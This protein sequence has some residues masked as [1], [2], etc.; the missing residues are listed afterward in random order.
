[1]LP[2]VLRELGWPADRRRAVYV[3]VF[4]MWS[5]VG[6]CAFASAMMCWTSPSFWFTSPCHLR[7]GLIS[8]APA[9]LTHCYQLRNVGTAQQQ[10][11]QSNKR[12][13][14]RGSLDSDSGGQNPVRSNPALPWPCLRHSSRR[15]SP[16]G[17]AAAL[18]PTRKR[19]RRHPGVQ[20]TPSVQRTPLV[21][22]TQS[23]HPR[24]HARTAQARQAQVLAAT[25]ELSARVCEVPLLPCG[26]PLRV[27]SPQR[28]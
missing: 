24:T 7:S 5:S 9:H 12:P 17:K 19:S 1:M 28:G 11:G 15:S 20:R 6:L 16:Q 23:V 18:H 27:P 4:G 14:A 22:R 25:Q 26:R 10:S 3:C 8:C 21:Q 13:H 2:A